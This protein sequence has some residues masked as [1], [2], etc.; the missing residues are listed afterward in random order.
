MIRWCVL[1][2]LVLFYVLNSGL[3]LLKVLVLK[4]SMGIWR[5][6][7]LSVWYFIC[8]FFCCM[9]VVWLWIDC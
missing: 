7:W 6:E 2:M 4:F 8:V 3:V 9:G 1:L 5:L